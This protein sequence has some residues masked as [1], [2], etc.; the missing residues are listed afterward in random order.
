MI[1]RVRQEVNIHRK[2]DHPS[3]LTL[4]TFFEDTDCVHLVL[5]LAHKGTLHQLLDERQKI[6]EYEAAIILSQVVDGLLYLHGK[7]IMHRDISAS[8]LLLTATMQVKIADF[9]LAAQLDQ[10]M[11]TN[12]TT[13]CGTPNYISPEVASRS[14][15][16]LPADAWAVGCL[17]YRMLVGQSP[18]N[19]NGAKSQLTQVVIG[20]LDVPYNISTEARDL[21]ERLLRKN[22]VQRIHL[23]D[24]VV[25]P[26][27][28][29]ANNQQIGTIDSGIMTSSS[30]GRSARS[31]SEVRSINQAAPMME[32]VVGSASMYRYSS[33][34][35]INQP[36][37]STPSYHKPQPMLQVSPLEL[38][39]K[40]IDVS[41]LS[42]V[43]LQ[44][45]RHLTK[46]VVLSILEEPPGEVV[47][48]F[49][50][51]KAKSNEGRVH[52]VCRI[53][54]DGLRIV[55][56]QPNNGKGVKVRDQPPE[57][58]SN[59]ADR[60]YNYENLPEKHWKK[61][62]YAHRFVQMVR[63]KT[64]KVTFYSDI[65]KCQLME[66]LE[67]FEMC[68]YKGGKVTKDST[69]CGFRVHF[70]K[71]PNLMLQERNILQH[72]EHCYQHC[73]QIEQ[74]MS[75][76]ALEFPCFP[77]IIGRRP[78]EQEPGKDQRPKNTF[79]NYIS[80][81]QTPVR[82][83]KI[84]MPSFSLGQS[85]SMKV[86][87]LGLNNY[88]VPET[89]PLTPSSSHRVTIP[90]IGTGTRL[91]NGTVEIQY[92]DGSQISA[93]AEGGG[94][95]YFSVPGKHQQP[96]HYYENDPMPE[97]VRM[98]YMQLPVFLEPLMKGNAGMITS[99]H[100]HQHTPLMSNRLTQMRNIR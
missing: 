17:L 73:V 38:Q 74:T 99:T 15:H 86:A 44:P 90:G 97:I 34:A 8:N 28:M 62:L 94:I 66:N 4:Y 36:Q 89:P 24:V 80:S 29:K 53:S 26:F 42:S 9:G 48:E 22:P 51:Y 20:N 1:E 39:T 16:G 54:S 11:Q 3:I 83:P 68:L 78:V 10:R 100:T 50:K 88:R 57:L 95:L 82:A 13:L 65:A 69:S 81:S 7:N 59:G 32:Q 14:N 79:N 56:Y 61:Y 46:T 37:F 40:K 55:L 35:S 96:I 2:L 33:S 64:P 23:K 31:R 52:D 98:K 43:R 30:I 67:D 70:E 75:L 27:M 6:S 85:S 58:P 18:F 25:H 12:H 93:P 41:P 72:A 63:A 71:N 45:T 84:N 76:M 91:S 77:I 5:E 49:I 92:V 87:P 19:G 60:I 21:I 47:L